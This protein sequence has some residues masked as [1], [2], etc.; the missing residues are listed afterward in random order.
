M[1]SYIYQ[2]V[3]PQVFAVKYDDVQMKERVIIRPRYMAICHA[4]QRYYLGKRAAKILKKKLPMALIHECC[5]E[6][7][8]D[9]TGTFKKGELVVPIPNTPLS[10]DN[11]IY[12]NY[13]KDSYFLSSGY[14]GFL[15]EY[16]DMPS[17][18]VVLAD[19]INPKIAAITEFVSVAVHAVKRFESI[20]HSRRRRI[21]IWGDGSLSYCLASILKKRFPNIDIIVV[22]K[23]ERKL[24]YFSFVDQTVLSE[25]L[26]EDLCVDHA[27]ECCG[28]EGS[29]YAIDDIIRLI[30]PQGMVVL[31]GVSEN[32]VAVNTRDVLEKGITMIGSSRSGKEDFENALEY[33]KDIHFQKRLE[34]IVY[35]DQTV[36]SIDDL[37]SVFHNDLNTPFKTVFEWK[38]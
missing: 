21:G 14:D 25:E 18:R 37:H 35:L 22:G 12:E 16:I 2:L 32:K 7:L 3:S 20:S 11:V 28:G 38:V 5:G 4:D 8:F 19:G 23:N 34:A 31:M 1:I 33:M 13:R 29:S 10:D 15:R 6:V 9:G 27:F 36:S 17:D 24:A 26:P 30:N